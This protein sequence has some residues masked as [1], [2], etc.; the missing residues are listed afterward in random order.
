MTERLF[1]QDSWM[2]EFCGKVLECRVCEEG[3]QVRLIGQHFIQKEADN[4]GIRAI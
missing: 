3:F 4:R 1:Y 2:R